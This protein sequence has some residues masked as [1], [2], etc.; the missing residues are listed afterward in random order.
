MGWPLGAIAKLIKTIIAKIMLNKFTA[1]S[2]AIC[3]ALVLRKTMAN[4]KGGANEIKIVLENISKFYDRLK[5]NEIKSVSI[6]PNSINYR[7]IK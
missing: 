6:L 1:A 3:M 5:A 2:L 7:D 4:R